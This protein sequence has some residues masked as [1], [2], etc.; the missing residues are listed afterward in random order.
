[1]SEPTVSPR[2]IRWVAMA[3][4]LVGIAGIVIGSIA[5]NTG[6]A[7]TSGLVSAVAIGYLI[8]LTAVIGRD[9][10]E[11]DDDAASAAPVDEAL[12]RDVEERVE[13]LVREGAD[14]HKLRQLVTRAVAL[15]RDRRRVG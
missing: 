7:I 12:A 14:E 15:G 4:G 2:A 9:A 3:I 13:E 8:V 6:L 11:R 10:F 5:N 1:M